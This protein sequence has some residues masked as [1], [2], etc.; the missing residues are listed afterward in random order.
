MSDR[1][2]LPVI[3]NPMKK[4]GLLRFSFSVLSFADKSFSA[5]RISADGWL[6]E[7]KSVC[8]KSTGCLNPSLRGL[9]W[10]IFWLSTLSK[11]LRGRFSLKLDLL[12]PPSREDSP[13]G[14]NFLT[15]CQEMVDNRFCS[16]SVFAVGIR[17]HH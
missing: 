5:N 17:N 2:F 6:F 7:T 13:K 8:C 12:M 4:F 9:V 16:L 1:N 15:P 3:L 14:L 11:V 10:F